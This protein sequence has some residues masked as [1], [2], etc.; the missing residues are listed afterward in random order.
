MLLIPCPNCGPRAEIEFICGGEA[1]E[2]PPD[3]AALDSQAWSAFVFTRTNAKG[4]I[5]ERWWHVHGCGR[6]FIVSRDTSTNAISTLP[7]AADR[8]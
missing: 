4:M 8:A 6:W 3:P 2:R 7:A 1:N 5:L